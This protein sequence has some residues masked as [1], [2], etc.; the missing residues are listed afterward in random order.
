M[1]VQRGLTWS[2]YFSLAY[3]RNWEKSKFRYFPMPM[4][5]VDLRACFEDFEVSGLD[6]VAEVS[7]VPMDFDVISFWF[8]DKITQL[9]SNFSSI[10]MI[11]PHIGTLGLH[12]GRRLF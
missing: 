1:G 5:L 7:S 3:S 12:L 2:I 4:S 11:C 8:V 9:M 6:T 10:E